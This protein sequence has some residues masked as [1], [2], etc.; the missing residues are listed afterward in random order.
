MTI[1]PKSFDRA[2]AELIDYL[3][4]F[5]ISKSAVPNG[6]T[7]NQCFFVDTHTDLLVGDLLMISS[8]QS[9]K[10]RL[11]WLVDIMQ[12][13][14]GYI[15]YLLKDVHTGEECWWTNIGT[16]YMDREIVKQHPQWKWTN[17]QYAFYDL[18]NQVKKEQD[19]YIIRT[20]IPDFDGEEVVI[21]TRTRFSIN[22]IQVTKTFHW[23]N[24][25]LVS[26]VPI[27]EEILKEHKDEEQKQRD[28]K[29]SP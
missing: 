16:A 1:N 14:D 5:A 12:K 17:E 23:R 10:W 2:G 28:A 25:D 29:A 24:H 27:H 6:R 21:R 18:W 9:K 3:L 13:P 20:W 19:E 8:T 22:D 11:S 15:E 4:Q 26:L 7:Y